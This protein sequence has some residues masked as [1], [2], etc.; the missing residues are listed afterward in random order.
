MSKS[1]PSVGMYT[2]R[3]AVTNS[4]SLNLRDAGLSFAF[5]LE[6]F[7]DKELKDDP[8]YVKMYVRQFGR[9]DGKNYEKILPHRKCRPEDYEEFSP[10]AKEAKAMLE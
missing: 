4:E 9:L 10:P 5:G 7:I 8:R 2:D 3:G 6:G 1:N